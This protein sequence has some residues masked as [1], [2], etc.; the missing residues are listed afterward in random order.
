MDLASKIPTPFYRASLIAIGLILTAVIIT[1]MDAGNAA[2]WSGDLPN[3]IALIAGVVFLFVPNIETAGL[4][5]AKDT[6]GTGA[7]FFHFAFQ[8]GW[9]YGTCLILLQWQGMEAKPA[10]IPITYF[11]GAIFGILMAWMQ[12]RR[13]TA[14][15]ARNAGIASS[16]DLTRPATETRAGRWFYH[17]MPLVAIATLLAM[18]FLPA[19]RKDGTLYAPFLLAFLGSMSGPIF[20][21][22][23]GPVS[24]R[25]ITFL[26]VGLLL[27]GL[28]G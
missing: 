27:F 14:N 6:D 16:Y 9:F 15:A 3:R 17:L 5:L 10:Q 2:P 19:L 24:P 8:T 4:A 25:L 26:G 1:M 7:P 13:S 22:T 18:L 11:F 21:I 23:K 12:S 28:M 20:P